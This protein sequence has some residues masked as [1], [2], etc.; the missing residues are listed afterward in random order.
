MSGEFVQYVHQHPPRCISGV[1]AVPTQHFRPT[2]RLP[3]H[4]STYHGQYGDGDIHGV[5]PV[6]SVI[7]C[8][9]GCRAV[10]LLGYNVL[11]EGPGKDMV[12]VGPLS[13]KCQECGRVSKFFD[14]REHGYDG[15][16]GCNT[17]IIGKGKPNKFS[18]P[19]CGEA[20]MIVCVNFSYQGVEG[21]R[22]EMRKRKQDFFNTLGV[23]V[24]CTKC[25]VLI[26]ATWFECD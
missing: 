22:G 8:S 15:E 23:V 25:N 5:D 3:R 6:S 10:Y 4:L 1:N 18:C 21:F 13:V 16:Q 24:Q 11:D 2:L 19:R 9:C 20:P 17:Y 12:L 14:T 26:E 7:G